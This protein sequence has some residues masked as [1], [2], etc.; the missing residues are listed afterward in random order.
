MIKIVR[1]II[2][3]IILII[4]IIF[5]LFVSLVKF[6]AQGVLMFGSTGRI[7]PKIEIMVQ[8]SDQ[9]LKQYIWRSY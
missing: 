2:I 6:G 8:K 1:N 9:W 3:E 7:P 4:W 5:C